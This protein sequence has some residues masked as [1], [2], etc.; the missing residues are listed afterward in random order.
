MFAEFVNLVP[1]LQHV[2]R[3]RAKIADRCLRGLH[4]AE[5]AAANCLDRAVKLHRCRAIQGLCHCQDVFIR[6]TFVHS[7]ICHRALPA[8]MPPA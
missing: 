3:G 5:R 6:W 4:F 2:R 7:S 8:L 1:F